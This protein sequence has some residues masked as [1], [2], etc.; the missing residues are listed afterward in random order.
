MATPKKTKIGFQD[1]LSLNAGQ[2]Y[3]RML[4][5]KKMKLSSLYKFVV[6][7]ENGKF[8]HNFGGKL[9]WERTCIRT[10]IWPR[11]IPVSQLLCSKTQKALLDTCATLLAWVKVFRINP[12]FRILRLTFHRKSASKC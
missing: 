6:L 1:R 8:N 10:E 7:Q 12:E 2:K 11:K 9:N 5:E 3:C 4:Q